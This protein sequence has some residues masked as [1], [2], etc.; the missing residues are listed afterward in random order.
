MSPVHAP[1]ALTTVISAVSSSIGR[2]KK[3]SWGRIISVLN[4]KGKH[5]KNEKAGAQYCGET[6]VICLETIEKQDMIRSLGC[7]HTF[8]ND[9]IME[10]IKIKKTCPI[11][12]SKVSGLK[13][14]SSCFQWYAHATY[15]DIWNAYSNLA[16]YTQNLVMRFSIVCSADT[17]QRRAQ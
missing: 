7:G 9:C 12:R 10:W 14:F 2:I 6:C 8:H 15:T 16:W 1:N 17:L 11:C 4:C 5:S 13:T 3:C